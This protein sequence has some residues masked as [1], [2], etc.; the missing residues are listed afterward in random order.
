[1]KEQRQANFLLA[2]RAA[3]FGTVPEEF[4]HVQMDVDVLV[5]P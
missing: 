5:Q 1:M 4:D 3:D 2:R